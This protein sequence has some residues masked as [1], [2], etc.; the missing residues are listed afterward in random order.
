MEFMIL[1]AILILIMPLLFI[2]SFIFLVFILVFTNKI[3]KVNNQEEKEKIK[4]KRTV[5]IV[6]LVVSVILFFFSPILQML[7]NLYKRGIV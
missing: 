6:L 2:S 5:F 4:K 1:Q 7:L 3:D